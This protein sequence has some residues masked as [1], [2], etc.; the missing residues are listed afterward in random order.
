MDGAPHPRATWPSSGDDGLLSLLLD[1]GSSTYAARFEDG[2][3][4]LSFH[5]REVRVPRRGRAHARGA[6]RHR[7]PA[8]AAA[9]RAE[10]TSVMPGVVKE[11]RVAPGQAVER[12]T[13]RCSSS[14]R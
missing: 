4:V 6:A 7:R 8:S 10:V 9:G 1:G 13:S 2:V 5:D 12:R 3:A 11:V 14:R